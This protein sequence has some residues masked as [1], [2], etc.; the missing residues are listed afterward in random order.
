VFELASA[1]L[2]SLNPESITSLAKP[3]SAF[4]ARLEP[5]MSI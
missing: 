1:H 3:G 5:L 2:R 4:A